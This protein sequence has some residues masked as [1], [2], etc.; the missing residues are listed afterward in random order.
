MVFKSITAEV[1]FDPPESFYQPEEASISK[2]MAGGI[3]A[4]ALRTRRPQHS[5]EAPTAPGVSDLPGNFT[6]EWVASMQ[7]TLLD[8]TRNG[9]GGLSAVVPCAK[10]CSILDALGKVLK[11]EP[12]VKEVHLS[13]LELTGSLAA[14]L[15][16]WR[17]KRGSSVPV[18]GSCVNP[19]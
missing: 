6:V 15:Q 8:S 3:M 13:E 17:R 7:K 19:P 12:T 11:C 18:N 5:D 4:T 9:I 10:V 1:T 14:I 2:E 16:W